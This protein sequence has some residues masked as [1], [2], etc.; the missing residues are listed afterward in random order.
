M[1]EEDREGIQMAVAH[2]KTA[3]EVVRYPQRDT[4]PMTLEVSSSLLV[5]SLRFLILK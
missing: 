1:V 2:D 3:E 4:D 5:R